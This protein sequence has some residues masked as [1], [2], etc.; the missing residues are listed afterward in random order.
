MR[1]GRISQGEKPV[2]LFRIQFLGFSMD[3]CL[4]RNDSLLSPSHS[5]KPYAYPESILGTFDRLYTLVRFKSLAWIPGQARND[6]ISVVIPES[7]RLIRNPGPLRFIFRS[8]SPLRSFPQNTVAPPVPCGAVFYADLRVSLDHAQGNG[9][10]II[11]ELRARP[12]GG[13]RG[14]STQSRACC[15]TDQPTDNPWRG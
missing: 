10:N 1:H 11:T 15:S 3:S 8:Q 13:S 2:G 9:A 6:D 14:S 7:R 12:R 5:G 4:H